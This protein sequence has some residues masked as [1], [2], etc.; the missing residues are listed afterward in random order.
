MKKDKTTDRGPLSPNDQASS[1]YSGN[2]KYN[3]EEDS[4]EYDVEKEESSYPNEEAE[5]QHDD[6][7]DS[8]APHGE[9]DNSDWDEANQYL[10]D[11]YDKKRSLETD[12]DELGMH[13]D[14]GRITRLNKKD[15]DL[16][17]TAEDSRTDLD[18]EGYPINDAKPLK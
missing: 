16:S 1:A 15:R 10:G 6:P 12:V 7:Y 3:E 18:E 9:D 2:L 14:H 5:Y 17:R 11:E 13:I 4:F 8:A